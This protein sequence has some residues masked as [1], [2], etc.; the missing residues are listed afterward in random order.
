MSNAIRG[1]V[2][3]P[4]RPSNKKKTPVR[5]HKAT[6]PFGSVIQPISPSTTAERGG[7]V[8]G[9]S[10]TVAPAAALN[11]ADTA[12]RGADPNAAQVMSAGDMAPPTPF[13]GQSGKAKPSSTAPGALATSNQATGS[14]ARSGEAQLRRHAKMSRTGGALPINDAMRHRAPRLPTP[15]P[16]FGG[17][18]NPGGSPT[19]QPTGGGTMYGVMQRGRG[20][21][22]GG[23][24][25]LSNLQ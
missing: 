11:N 19:Q 12:R 7:P 3:G 4:R 21:K 16:T 10:D 25:D 5:V 20:K 13:P 8:G 18:D 1:G 17:A 2:G 14:T 24:G 9:L 22:S 6:G 23:D 15:G